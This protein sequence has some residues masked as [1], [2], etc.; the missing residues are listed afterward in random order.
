MVY[1][2]CENELDEALLSPLK[3]SS[4]KDKKKMLKD[5]KQFPSNNSSNK[6]EKSN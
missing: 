2:E 3:S 5:G 1:N 4:N 6:L